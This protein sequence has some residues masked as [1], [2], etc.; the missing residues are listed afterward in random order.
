MDVSLSFN[1]NER[2][3]FNSGLDV[4]DWLEAGEEIDNTPP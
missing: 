1:R 3:G 4:Q 2:C